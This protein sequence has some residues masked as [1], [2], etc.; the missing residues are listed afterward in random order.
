MS[1]RFR[2]MREARRLVRLLRLI[3]HVGNGVLLAYAGFAVL[4]AAGLDSHHTRR[5]SI[6]RWWMRRLLRII[7]VRVHVQG[8]PPAVCALF[9]L[10]HISWLDIPVVLSVLDA[11]FVSKQEVRDWPVIGGLAARAGT[12]F[13]ARGERHTLTHAADHMTW[14]LHQG[15]AVAIFPEGTT[16]DG[17]CVLR[18]HAR[19]YQAAIRTRTLVQA[20]ALHYPSGTIGVSAT[21]DHQPSTDTHP[22]APF[23][24]EMSL[25]RHLWALL[26]ERELTAGLFFCKPLAASQDRRGLADTTRQQVVN[27]LGFAASEAA[28][29]QDQFTAR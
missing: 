7:N 20:V 13:L 12:I 17:S 11:C 25:A 1:R 4:A 3:M 6:V 28:P 5:R 18:F 21:A 22:A 9:V 29:R 24:G 15:R 26:G 8:E 10:N 16:T 23:V 27:A 19:L 2:L 14:A